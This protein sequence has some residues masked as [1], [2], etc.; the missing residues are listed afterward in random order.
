M[1]D[2]LT[3][4]SLFIIANGFA[5]GLGEDVF[6]NYKPDSPHDIVCLF[7]YSGDKIQPGTDA[8]TRRIQILVRNNDDDLCIQTINGIFNLLDNPEEE[9][10]E[11]EER[12][13]VTQALQPPFFFSRDN[14]DRASYIF[15]ISITT[16][17]D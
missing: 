8:V 4:I 17:R 10:V 14:D 5:S 9:I 12:K 7:E 15:N 3:D 11:L 13:M 1:A 6:V 16:K 2:L